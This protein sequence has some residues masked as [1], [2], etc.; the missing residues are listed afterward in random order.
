MTP[1][2]LSDR[3]GCA[4]QTGNHILHRRKKRSVPHAILPPLASTLSLRPSAKERCVKVQ[5]IP[6]AYLI[7]ALE[8]S[9]SRKPP[10]TVLL[11]ISRVTKFSSR[12]HAHLNFL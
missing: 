8:L 7:V 10:T 5:T 3:L 2:R 1:C 11:R 4:L 6:A 9:N 12:S